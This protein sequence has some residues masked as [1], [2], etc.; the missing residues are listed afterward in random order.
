MK[1]EIKNNTQT[2]PGSEAGLIRDS[3][4]GDKFYIAVGKFIVIVSAAEI[5]SVINKIEEERQNAETNVSN[6]ADAR[7]DTTSNS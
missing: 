7:V 4:A 1:Y 3:I 2:L 6:I 5:I